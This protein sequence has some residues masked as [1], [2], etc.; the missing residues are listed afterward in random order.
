MLT[1]AFT[2]PVQRLVMFLVGGLGMHLDG[3]WLGLGELAK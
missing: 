3:G 1:G 2:R